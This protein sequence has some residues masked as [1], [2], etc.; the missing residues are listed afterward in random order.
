MMQAN[1]ATRSRLST[2]INPGL[3]SLAQTQK[4]FDPKHCQPPRVGVALR[5]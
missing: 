3:G 2:A 4:L 5:F 1:R